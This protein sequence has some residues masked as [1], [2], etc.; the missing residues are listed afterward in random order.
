MTTILNGYVVLLLLNPNRW[1][2][3]SIVFMEDY[4]RDNNKKKTTFI[5]KVW[6]QL[7]KYSS[8]I[9]LRSSSIGNQHL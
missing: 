3:S 9:Q 1:L 8:F 2:C 4:F 5:L 7:Y 6:A